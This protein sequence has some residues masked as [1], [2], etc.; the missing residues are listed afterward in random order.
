C[1]AEFREDQRLKDIDRVRDD[2]STHDD[3]DDR[4]NCHGE[5]TQERKSLKSYTIEGLVVGS[6]RGGSQ[7]DH[8]HWVQE[9]LYK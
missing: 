3:D 7:G 2:D 4:E 5:T 8:P 1:D 9:Q 6:S